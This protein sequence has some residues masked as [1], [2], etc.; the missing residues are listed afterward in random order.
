MKGRD[1]SV[2]G[3][4]RWRRRRAL[5]SRAGGWYRRGQRGRERARERGAGVRIS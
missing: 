5:A 3:E 4:W 1:Q 2:R